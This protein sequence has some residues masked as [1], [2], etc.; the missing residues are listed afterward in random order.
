MWT[1]KGPLHRFCEATSRRAPPAA[2]RTASSR[3]SITP[4]TEG[5]P[6]AIEQSDAATG[7]P[8]SGRSP[9]HPTTRESYASLDRQPRHDDLAVLRACPIHFVDG[10]LPAGAPDASA[11]S[12]CYG[13]MLIALA[14]PHQPRGWVL[15]EKGRRQ[16]AQDGQ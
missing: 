1:A 8:R 7:D 6:P 11:I 12:H 5:P 10:L 15:T 13:N 9:I 3:T 14:N 16:L 4:A 2:R